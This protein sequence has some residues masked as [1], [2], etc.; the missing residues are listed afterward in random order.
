[1][2]ENFLS[3]EDVEALKA[4]CYDLVE[5]MDPAK[6]HTVFST[7]KQVSQGYSAF[8][9]HVCVP[10]NCYLRMTIS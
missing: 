10:F 4:E 9:I 6:Y 3:D 7:T 5:K 8:Y 1:M 2:L